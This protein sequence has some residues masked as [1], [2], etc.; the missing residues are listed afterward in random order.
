MHRV[1][2]STCLF[3]P[4]KFLIETKY[5]HHVQK[6]RHSTRKKTVLYFAGN[7]LWSLLVKVFW[8]SVS[9]W[10]S[11]HFFPDTV[12]ILCEEFSDMQCFLICDSE[13]WLIIMEREAKYYRT[14]ASVIRWLIIGLLWRKESA[15]SALTLLVG[16]QEGQP[17]CKKWDGGGGH[18]LVRME[19]RPARLS[20][21]LPLLIFPCTIKSRS[22]LLALAHPG[23]PG[24]RAVKWLWCGVV[25]ERKCRPHW[26]WWL[27]RVDAGGFVHVESKG[28]TWIRHS[29][30]VVWWR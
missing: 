22:S 13:T 10:Q 15:F 2:L 21:C 27:G 7:L 6:K 30:V 28:D 24:K 9:I 3:Q 25:M 23:G 11:W 20:V 19:W 17:A 18:W 1:F 29:D 26:V 8:K 5:I 16:W 14:E 4:V 12:Y